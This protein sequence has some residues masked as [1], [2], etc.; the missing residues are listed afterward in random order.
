M[1]DYI[2]RRIAFTHDTEFF[3]NGGDKYQLRGKRTHDSQG[4]ESIQLLIGT[5]KV[6]I[7]NDDCQDISELASAMADTLTQLAQNPCT[8]PV[9]PDDSLNMLHDFEDAEFVQEN[10]TRFVKANASML[11]NKTPSVTV[12]IPEDEAS[13]LFENNK[14]SII[15]NTSAALRQC[16]IKTNPDPLAEFPAAP[17]VYGNAV[18]I[19]NAPTYEEIL[20]DFSTQLW[21]NFF[22]CQ[23]WRHDE[24]N[25]RSP[26]AGMLLFYTGNGAL[27]WH[28]IKHTVV[29]YNRAKLAVLNK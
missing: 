22:G 14:E 2:E 20:H 1:K 29:D 11:T 21:L 26:K 23:F 9:V 5:Q 19:T 4:F 3:D 10:S 18:I 6:T 13:R 8:L 12:T 24:N 17:G 25:T 27:N 28:S 16:G 7:T 15:K